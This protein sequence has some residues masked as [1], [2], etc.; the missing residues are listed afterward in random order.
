MITEDFRPLFENWGIDRSRIHVLH[1]WS[2]LDELPLRP[3][4]N[5]WSREH[6]LSAGPRFLY[7]GT[8]AMKHN[9]KL[10]LELAKLLDERGG[11]EVIVVSEGLGIDWLRREGDAAGVKSLRYFPFQPFERV[12]DVLGSADVL[13]V[14][15]D[16]DAGAFCV[17]S[18]VLSYMCAGRAVLGAMP[19]QNLAARVVTDQN[20]GRVVEPDDVAGFRQAAIELLDS[21]QLRAECGAAA[22]RYADAAF[23]IEHI[24]DRMEDLLGG[25]SSAASKVVI[26]GATPSQSYLAAR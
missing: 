19:R 5:A 11:G 2:A 25:P 6:G 22:R 13:V 14:L 18:K 21:P 8:M 23:D 1:N 7:S 20:A 12:A 26:P 16:A 24:A 17:P 9:P 15:L 3:R 4:D 10:L